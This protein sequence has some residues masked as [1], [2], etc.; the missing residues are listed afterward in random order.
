MGPEVG[1]EVRG[2]VKTPAA[3]L[4]AQVPVRVLALRQWRGGGR[5]VGGA[6]GARGAAV[7]VALGV[8]YAVGDEAVPAQGTRRCEADAALQAL[9]GGGVRSVLG[10]VPLKLRPVLCGKAAGNAT[11]N[12]FFLQL[13]GRRRR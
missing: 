10:D 6:V 5:A 8:P 9:E 7:R 1:V 12:V 13:A 2:F 4:T 3:H 11:E